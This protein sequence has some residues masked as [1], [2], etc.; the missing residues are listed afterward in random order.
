MTH[1]VE[2]NGRGDIEK[3][4]YVADGITRVEQAIYADAGVHLRIRSVT[5]L[6]PGLERS[7]RTAGGTQRQNKL[8]RVS[9]RTVN[10]IPSAPRRRTLGRALRPLQ[11]LRPES[12]P[13]AA[14]GVYAPDGWLRAEIVGAPRIGQVYTRDAAGHVTQSYDSPTDPQPVNPPV[15]GQI[16]EYTYRPTVSSRPRPSTR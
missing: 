6:R 3:D 13:R 1:Q 12:R 2:I 5:R 8:F 15:S 4:T 14:S 16:A 7:F 9:H 10:G 11:D